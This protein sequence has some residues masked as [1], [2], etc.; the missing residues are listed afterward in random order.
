MSQFK[1]L[2]GTR[3]GKLTVTSYAGN[4]KWNCIC[5]CGNATVVH[6]SN[7]GR[8]TNSC[9]CLRTSDLTGR[10]F[11]KWTCMRK[12]SERTG[13]LSRWICRCDCGKEKSVLRRSLISGNSKGCGCDR[14]ENMAKVNTVHGMCNTR[15]YNIW[16]NMRKRC[17]S[18][19][20]TSYKNY[21]GRGIFV[22]EEWRYSFENFK[23]WALENG[24]ADD[25][26][27]DRVDVNGGYC[28]ENCRWTT[29]KV[30]GRNRTCNI[31]ITYKG[32]TKTLS[33]WSEIAGINWHTLYGRL[34]NNWDVEKAFTLEPIIG[35]NQY[36]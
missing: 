7:L 36:S 32:E 29:Y 20:S 17:H 1:D 24:Y 28:P 25:L 23:D 9:G 33:E 11:G 14:G 12:D 21:G 13:R 15:L 16:K 31:L 34:K 30:Q 4:K 19:N 22:C 3:F 26:T 10:K 8:I 35:R 2:T 27:I 6:R 5:D 18:E